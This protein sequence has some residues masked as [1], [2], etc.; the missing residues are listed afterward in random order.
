MRACENLTFSSIVLSFF[1]PAMSYSGIQSRV[2]LDP[3][4]CFLLNE[5]TMSTEEVIEF[6]IT[7]HTAIVL[8]PYSKNSSAE[9]YLH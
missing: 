2:G 9:L 1:V 7:T 5:I 6:I 3:P 4:T 8:H